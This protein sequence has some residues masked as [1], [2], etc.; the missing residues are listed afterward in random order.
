[1]R[2]LYLVLCTL[3]FVLCTL[4][5]VWTLVFELCSLYFVFMMAEGL[6]ES[7]IRNQ[8]TKTKAQRPKSKDQNQVLLN[9]LDSHSRLQ[10][11][12]ID[13]HLFADIHAG[14]NLS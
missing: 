6:A 11:S 2:T 8:R 10:V 1:M 12:R 3:Y 14:E 5:S 13:D 4:C 9:Y 7:S